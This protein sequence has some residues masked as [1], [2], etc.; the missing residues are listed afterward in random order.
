MFLQFSDLTHTVKKWLKAVHINIQG[1]SPQQL[2][3]LISFFFKSKKGSINMYNILDRKIGSFYCRGEVE[4]NISNA[5]SILKILN[6]PGF[7]IELF[8]E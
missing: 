7:S 6:F 4:K 2:M 5:R 8:T 1:E 3:Y